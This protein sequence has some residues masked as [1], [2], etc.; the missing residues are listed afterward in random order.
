MG[1]VLYPE[2]ELLFLFDNVTYHEIY[3]QNVLPVTYINKGPGSQQTFLYTGWY[4]K[5]NE[6]II[7][8][9]MCL[10]SRNYAIG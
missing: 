5:V 4:K 3:V 7:L 1:E 8:Q 10:L 2:Y 9:E 6:K